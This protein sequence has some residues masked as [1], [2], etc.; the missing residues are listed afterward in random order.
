MDSAPRA[1]VL[2]DAVTGCVCICSVFGVCHGR[3]CRM[4]GRIGMFLIVGGKND[5]ARQTGCEG[6]VEGPRPL[7]PL[8]CEAVHRVL[9][10][11][12]WTGAMSNALASGISGI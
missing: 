12:S 9:A 1:A 7:N 5:I 8:A 2:A 4:I 6:D 10:M 11:P 3:R